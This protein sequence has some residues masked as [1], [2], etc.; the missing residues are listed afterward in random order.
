ME[1]TLLEALSG[2]LQLYHNS[3]SNKIKDFVLPV[4]GLNLLDKKASGTII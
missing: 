2:S 4:N 3:A 1:N